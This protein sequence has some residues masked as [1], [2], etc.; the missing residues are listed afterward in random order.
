MTTTETTAAAEVAD[1]ADHVPDDAGNLVIEVQPCASW[2]EASPERH[3]MEH[4]A[5]RACWSDWKTL[6]L[7]RHQPV[8]LSRQGPNAWGYD[9]LTVNTSHHPDDAEA[10]VGVHILESDAEIRL[11]IAEARQLAAYLTQHADLAEQGRR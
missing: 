8:Q 4:P 1:V 7:S 9:W 10:E 2:C 5:D 3:A 6:K 11:T